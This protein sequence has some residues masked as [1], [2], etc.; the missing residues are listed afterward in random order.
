MGIVSSPQAVIGKLR[1]ATKVYRQ[2]PTLPC[3]DAGMPRPEIRKYK[4]KK[5]ISDT[6]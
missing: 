1:E 3:F 2:E 6:C 4:C 5:N